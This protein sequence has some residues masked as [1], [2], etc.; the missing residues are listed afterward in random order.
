MNNHYMKKATG[1][2]ALSL[3]VLAMTGCM[4]TQ[5]L[6][7]GITQEGQ[8]QKAD[9]VFPELNKAWQPDGLFPNSENLAKIKPGIDKDELYKLI[10]TPHFQEGFNAREWDYMM[11]FHTPNNPDM[12][13]TVCQYKIIFDKEYKGQEFYWKPDNSTV[14][15]P[16]AINSS[17]SKLTKIID[18]EK[19]IE[20]AKGEVEVTLDADAL[21][22]FASAKLN[23]MSPQ[24]R[25]QL[26]GLSQEL[27]EY[28]QRGDIKVIIT[29]HADRIGKDGDNMRLSESRAYTVA[30]YLIS[31]GIE[32]S[33][34]SAGGMGESQPLVQC[35]TALPR[36]QQ[37]DCL[38][39]NRR[40]TVNVNG[41][42]AGEG[43]DKVTETRR[44][45]L[46][47]GDSYVELDADLDSYFNN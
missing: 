39:P 10:G 46:V 12:P 42:V 22:K 35:S 3:A 20:Q 37:I 19:T 28:Q 36:Q 6:S 38:Q 44:E 21:F 18:R 30:N 5:H 7:K 16:Q 27:R 14:C 26:D 43:S 41:V 11:K 1:L 9:I 8:V 32:A 31:Q 17:S 29:G 40:V 45:V 33:N 47:E 15:P 34:I 2:G 13:V 25:A 23:D 24:G 4:G